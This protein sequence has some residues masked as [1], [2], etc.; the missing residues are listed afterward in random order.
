MLS[1]RIE[2]ARLQTRKRL[3]KSLPNLARR[4][5]LKN[6]LLPS[7]HVDFE[8]ALLTSAN[9]SVTDERENKVFGPCA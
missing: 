7:G 2:A 4:P 1:R 9:I 8:A 3:F 5:E 6:H